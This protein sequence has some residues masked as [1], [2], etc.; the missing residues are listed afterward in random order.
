MKV[1]VYAGAAYIFKR[2]G[3]TWSQQVKIIATDKAAN[4][5]FGYSV[6]LS[7]DYAIVG[8]YYEDEGGSNAV[9]AYIFKRSGTTWSE[10]AKIQASD[11]QAGDHFGYSVSIAGD[12]AIVG[13]HQEDEGGSYAGAAYIF[14]GI[15]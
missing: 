9:A 1:E 8:A 11:K 13:A 4:D 7:G 2:S 5:R 12:Y 14:R 15:K 3:T 6:A 10:Q